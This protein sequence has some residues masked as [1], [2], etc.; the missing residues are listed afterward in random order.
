MGDVSKT[1][2][3]ERVDMSSTRRTG[4]EQVKF[5]QFYEALLEAK[6][7]SL[8]GSSGI[9]KGGRK[10]SYKAKVQGTGN[11]LIGMAYTAM[12]DLKPGDEFTIKLSG[13]KGITLIPIGAE[14][15]SET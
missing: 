9:G 8:G 4:P 14:D 11:L 15:V 12:L 2:L 13:R 3:A 6:G 1:E 10:L 5:T 7:V